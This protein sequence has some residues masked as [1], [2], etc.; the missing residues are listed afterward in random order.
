LG[1]ADLAAATGFGF[2]AG[3]D[4]VDAVTGAATEE[5]PV[6]AEAVAAGA[7]A[8]ASGDAADAVAVVLLAVVG[9]GVTEAAGGL[10][11]TAVAGADALATGVGVADAG[12]MAAP[13][14]V[15]DA[16]AVAAGGVAGLAALAAEPSGNAGPRAPLAAGADAAAPGTPPDF[17]CRRASSSIFFES[18]A[19]RSVVSLACR[20]SAICA[21]ADLP[22]TPPL[23]KVSL[24]GDVA[25][26][27]FS[28]TL[29]W[30]LPEA[31]RSAS[32]TC[33]AGAAPASFLR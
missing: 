2:D 23:D 19:T 11:G 32:A 33:L 12:A 20:D 8:T 9:L 31:L 27:F 29:A 21:S 13:T 10:S 1:G 3:A 15:P 5:A 18:A 16:L 25:T 24:S 4:A 17:S 14:G 7:L 6:A 28:S 30:R 22:F 26:G